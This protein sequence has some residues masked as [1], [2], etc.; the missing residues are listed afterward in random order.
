MPLTEEEIAGLE[1]RARAIRKRIVRVAYS[2][3]GG[4]V[5]GSLS[6]TDI[7]TALYF[8]Y[9]NIDPAN[10]DKP[11]RDRFIL[12]KGHAGLGWASALG[13]AGYFDVAL[14]DDFNKT[15]SAFGM[16]L[17][18]LKVPGVDA[19]T[20]SLGHGLALAVGMAKAAQLKGESWNTY[21]MLGDGELCEGT[22][23]EAMMLATF[24]KL[25]NLIGFVDRNRLMIDGPTE[26]ITSLDPLSEKFTAFG[27]ECIEIDGHDMRAIGDA[28][29]QAQAV[30]GKPTMIICETIKGKGVE[31]FEGVAKWHYGGI[32]SD[33]RDQA[34]ADID[35]SGTR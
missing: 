8:K 5:G 13:E 18:S 19:S 27:W 11:D 17:D 4:H 9:L 21:V 10:P 2:A 1:S 35:S 29:E 32:D 20:G 22:N 30:S 7:V 6:Q 34:M 16:H 14:L 12:S 15:G 26:E 31:Q 3:G 24:H 23:W 28:I 33:M 25:D